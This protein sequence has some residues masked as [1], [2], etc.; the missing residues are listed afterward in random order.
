M[1]YTSQ[2]EPT[3]TKALRRWPR[4]SRSTGGLQKF[5]WAAGSMWLALIHAAPA[6]PIPLHEAQGYTRVGSYP[7]WS[8]DRSEAPEMTQ[9][10]AGSPR[11]DQCLAETVGLHIS[12]CKKIL[13]Q[14][15]R[16][17]S[18]LWGLW[19]GLEQGSLNLPASSWKGGPYS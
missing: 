4:E 9:P 2:D 15:T 3:M 12:L 10:Q 8:P 1:V 14:V 5:L 7:S 17:E 19:V 16:L 18:G 11:K 6:E 13:L